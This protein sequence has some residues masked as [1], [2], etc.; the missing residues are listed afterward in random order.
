MKEDVKWINDGLIEFVP[1]VTY[2]YYPRKSRGNRQFDK[3]TTINM[4]LIV[5]FILP[6]I[7]ID[8]NFHSFNVFII[9]RNSK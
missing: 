7:R 3:I 2:R 6:T 4:P 1:K 9:S 8:V 5:S